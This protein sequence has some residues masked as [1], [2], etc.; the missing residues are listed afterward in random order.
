MEKLYNGLQMLIATFE[1]LYSG[2]ADAY[3]YI[4]LNG[5]TVAPEMFI[6]TFEKLSSGNDMLIA[7]FEKR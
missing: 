4:A 5:F 6:A 1:R 7:T 2:P 3:S